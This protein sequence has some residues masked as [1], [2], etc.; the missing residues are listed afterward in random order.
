MGGVHGTSKPAAVRLEKFANEIPAK[1]AKAL[2]PLLDQLT[3]DMF[4]NETDVYDSPFAP[5]A[6][7]TIRRKKGN[8]VILSRTNELGNSTYVLYTG[9]RLV[10]TYGQS[11]VY[12]QDGDQGRGNRPPR[13]LAPPY[14]PPKSWNAAVRQAQAELAKRKA[15]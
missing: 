5:L 6:E 15:S 1:L 7:S 11:A 2:A 4:T 13:L 14:G 9:R 10:F 12:A 8:S 3:R